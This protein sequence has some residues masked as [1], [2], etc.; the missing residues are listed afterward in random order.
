MHR[1]ICLCFFSPSLSLCVPAGEREEHRWD[2]G[3]QRRAGCFLGHPGGGGVAQRLI[4]GL[5]PDVVGMEVPQNDQ[6]LVCWSPA[7][8]CLGR[9]MGRLEGGSSSG[10]MVPRASSPWRDE[11]KGCLSN[12]PRKLIIARSR[13]RRNELSG[14]D[15]SPL[16]LSGSAESAV[17]GNVPRDASHV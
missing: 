4:W 7:A 14:P 12:D 16:L 6:S 10:G 9:V 5:K 3:R 15:S 11:G 13:S 1:N 8:W 2:G 17:G